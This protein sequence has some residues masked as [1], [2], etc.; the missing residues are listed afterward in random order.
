MFTNHYIIII[1]GIA[2]YLDY[3]FIF[4]YNTK[5]QRNIKTS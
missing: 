5:L 3:G 1:L 4:P 2:M